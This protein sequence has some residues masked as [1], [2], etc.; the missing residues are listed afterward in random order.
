MADCIRRSLL[1]PVLILGFVSSSFSQ[2]E[3][4]QTVLATAPFT[5]GTPIDVCYDSLTN[6][7]YVLDGGNGDTHVYTAGLGFLGIAPSPFPPGSVANGIT[8]DPV[9]GAVLWTILDPTGTPQL[10]AAV[11]IAS[12]P[13]VGPVCPGDGNIPPVS[14]R[15]QSVVS[16]TPVRHDS[17]PSSPSRL[18]KV[19]SY[20]SSL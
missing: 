16:G 17:T 19:G 2:G 12:A 10:W 3:S 11:N 9:N 5:G 4:L 13:F 1:V 18:R 14:R 6:V 15:S 20:A 7:V 8:A